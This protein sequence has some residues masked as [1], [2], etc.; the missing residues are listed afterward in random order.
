MEGTPPPPEGR[1]DAQRSKRR[2]PVGRINAPREQNGRFVKV[3]ASY[4]CAGKPLPTTTIH[5]ETLVNDTKAYTHTT[6]PSSSSSSPTPTD[7]NIDVGA[8]PNAF[9]MPLPSEIVNE[10][11]NHSILPH[12]KT[13]S[14]SE[15]QMLVC[16]NI[17]MKHYRSQLLNFLTSA[18]HSSG[19]SSCTY[20]NIESIVCAAMTSLGF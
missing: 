6:N 19:S 15:M 18:L 8:S 16:K 13:A 14:S 1:E 12:L 5:S 3:P 2:T 4:K 10:I 20:K 7:R 11:F 9:T 17:F